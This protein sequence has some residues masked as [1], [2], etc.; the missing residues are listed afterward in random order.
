VLLR[1]A[2]AAVLLLGLCRVAVHGVAWGI[3]LLWCLL[4]VR[5][6]C[7]ERANSTVSPIQIQS[8]NAWRNPG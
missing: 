1:R 2:A 6:I 4:G 8:S 5:Q 7:E 3:V